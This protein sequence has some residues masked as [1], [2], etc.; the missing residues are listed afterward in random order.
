MKT[1]LIILSAILMLS[2]IYPLSIQSRSVFDAG[3]GHR[4][5][6][7]NG[8]NRQDGVP[9]AK[10][11]QDPD[12]K[13]VSIGGGCDPAPGTCWET[14]EGGRILIVYDLVTHPGPGID[15]VFMPVPDVP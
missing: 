2:L 11:T 12:T 6:T 15:L 1:P 13:A 9:R 4:W 10:A 5:M 7:P 14:A 3:P 8:Q